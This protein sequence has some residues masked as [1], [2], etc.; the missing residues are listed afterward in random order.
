MTGVGVVARMVSVTGMTVVTVAAMAGG[1]AVTRVNGVVTVAAVLSMSVMTRVPRMGVMIR[2]AGMAAVTHMPS[3]IFPSRMAGMGTVTTIADRVAT[4]RV[5][6]MINVGT[7]TCEVRVIDMITM[8]RTPILCQISVA[9]MRRIARSIY[10][11][12]VTTRVC[13]PRMIHIPH[14]AACIA[15]PAI[16]H[17]RLRI[18]KRIILFTIVRRVE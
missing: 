14:T 13:A 2:M 8:Q 1:I 10:R 12:R 18:G 3:G 11:G 7:T 15:F 6:A 16:G 17:P 4:T 5:T 9:G